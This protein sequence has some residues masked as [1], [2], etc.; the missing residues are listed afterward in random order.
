MSSI[1]PESSSIES[2]YGRGTEARYIEE[3]NLAGRSGIDR[4]SLE[5]FALHNILR[6]CN[7]QVTLCG[8]SYDQS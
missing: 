6:A 2:D 4:F 1:G 5:F 8:L 7:A 3:P